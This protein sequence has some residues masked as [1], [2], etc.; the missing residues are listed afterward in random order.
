[1]SISISSFTVRP[2]ACCHLRYMEEETDLEKG[3]ASL[4]SPRVRAKDHA[5]VHLGPIYNFLIL[6]S[7][8]LYLSQCRNRQQILWSKKNAGFEGPV[9]VDEGCVTAVSSLP[10]V[11]RT[12]AV[13]YTGPDFGEETPTE[14]IEY[15]WPWVLRECKGAVLEQQTSSCWKPGEEG[16]I[17]AF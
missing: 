6:L 7:V 9:K 4:S 15:I 13:S 17:P 3:R 16:H 2:K 11:W 5:G 14:A 10:W 8:Q 12:Q 1:M